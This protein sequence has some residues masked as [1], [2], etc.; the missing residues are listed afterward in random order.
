MW[1]GFYMLLDENSGILVT[2][3]GKIKLTRNEIM[4]FLYL[5]Y[6][7]KHIYTFQELIIWI[8]GVDNY[9]LFYNCFRKMLKK[10]R[11]KIENESLQIMIIDNY[12]L[13][14]HYNI[15]KKIKNKIKIYSKKIKIDKLNQEINKLNQEIKL[16]EEVK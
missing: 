5:I 14:I 2:K 8:Y 9:K 1:K 3:N 11:K 12:N 6:T 7:K 10:I 15:D 16:L 13:S 4:F